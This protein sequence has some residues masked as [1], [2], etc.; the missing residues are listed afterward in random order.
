M[1]QKLLL[2]VVL[3]SFWFRATSYAFEPLFD[4]WIGYDV[5]GGASSIFASDLDGD[6]DQDLAVSGSNISILKNNGDGT[7]APAVVYPGS[8]ISVTASDLDGN[9]DQDVVIANLGT[10]CGWDLCPD[11]TVSVLM[12]NGDGTFNI[13]KRVDY[14][15]GPTPSSVYASDFDQDN[16]ND[17]VV[18][19]GS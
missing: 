9:G 10:V 19:N 4:T 6:R 15:V 18:S 12:N 1:L 2:L 5:Q 8:G 13:N 16:D 3:S 17:L 14:R 7:F 11:S